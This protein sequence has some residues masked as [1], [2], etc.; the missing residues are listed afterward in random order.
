M[1][2]SLN[3][4]RELFTQFGTP[5]SMTSWGEYMI[6]TVEPGESGGARLKVR[7]RPK[8]ANRLLGSTKWGEDIHSRKVEKGSGRG[9]RRGAGARWRLGAPLAGPRPM[10][11][12]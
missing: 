3:E 10:S 1:S 9:D 6:A 8:A 2:P 11:D 12:A 7:G 4:E 5:P